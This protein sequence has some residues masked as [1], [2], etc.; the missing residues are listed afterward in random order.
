MRPDETATAAVEIDRASVLRAIRMDEA[1][2]QRLGVLLADIVE[3]FVTFR[4]LEPIQIR[5]VVDD[6]RLSGV[7][8]DGEYEELLR[9]LVQTDLIEEADT[10]GHFTLGDAVS[11]LA[12]IDD[13]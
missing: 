8:R 1:D 7:L 5:R 3:L 2:L 13:S 10:T 11:S 12:E 9:W 6:A 4:R